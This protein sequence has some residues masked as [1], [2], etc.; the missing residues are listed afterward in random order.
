MSNNKTPIDKGNWILENIGLAPYKLFKSYG[1]LV[2]TIALFI[3]IVW[4][5]I[6]MLV[7]SPYFI[8]VMVD[9]IIN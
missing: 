4:I 5:A 9:E 2:R 6:I 8:Y 1:V 7:L 3:S